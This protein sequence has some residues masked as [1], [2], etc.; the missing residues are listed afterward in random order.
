MGQVETKIKLTLGVSLP[1]ERPRQL[2][3]ELELIKLSHRPGIKFLPE[4]NKQLSPNLFQL[5]RI[6]VLL[7]ILKTLR[8]QEQF[9][10][11]LLLMLI[12]MTLNIIK[13][14]VRN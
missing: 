4:P 14:L 11:P 9:Q 3:A 12:T 8:G 6:S 2:E 5:L 1:I 13:D 7:Q 10:L